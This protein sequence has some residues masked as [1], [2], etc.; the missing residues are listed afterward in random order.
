MGGVMT[1]LGTYTPQSPEWYEA[2]RWRIG[3]SEVSVILGMSPWQ[4]TS[5]DLMARKLAGTHLDITPAMMRGHLLEPAVLAW[6]VEKHGLAYDPALS[7][8]TY[9]STE[10]DWALA[11][12]DAITT[13]A[14]LVEA[15][16]THNRNTEDGWGR[17]GTAAIPLAYACQVEWACGVIGLERWTLLVLAGGLNGRPT[18]DFAAYRGTHNPTRYARMVA[19]A[20]RWHDQLI[21]EREA[22]A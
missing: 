9:A 5:A 14:T 22:A 11:N 21:A 18:L 19:A 6:G 2:R 10:H 1:T 8:A 3:A 12:P 20:A 13:D 17:A 4:E 16:T 15:K 7:A